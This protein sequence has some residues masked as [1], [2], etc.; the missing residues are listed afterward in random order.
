MDDSLLDK[1]KN[2]DVPMH[3]RV[4]AIFGAT[5]ALLQAAIPI[6]NVIA[7]LQGS[8]TD[9]EDA[10]AGTYYRMCFCVESLTRLN[11]KR[12]F[13]VALGVTRT[14]YELYIDMVELSTVPI[15]AAKFLDYT[16]V[17]KFSA[18]KKLVDELSHQGITDPTIGKHERAF[19]G[20][21]KNQTKYQAEL[22]KHWPSKQGQAAKAPLSWTNTNLP[23]RVKAIGNAELLRYRKIYSMLC[24]YSHSGLVG[25]A[26]LSAEGLESAMGF[27]HAYSQ[28]V[29]Y[30]ATNLIA[31]V[32]KIYIAN[33]NLKTAVDA[34]KAATAK[35][36]A[37]YL[38]KAAARNTT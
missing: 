6:R 11:N 14:I 18:A 15:Q 16:F 37:T 2:I 4:N 22:L 27:G 3:E 38:S 21:P 32:F 19:I 35:I 23:T 5:Q 26:N 36:L 28:D 9:F 7:T 25:V 30:E 1:L 24:W 34:Y 17:A 13:Q 33:P 29:F 10:L 8:R 12:D 20:D 31:G